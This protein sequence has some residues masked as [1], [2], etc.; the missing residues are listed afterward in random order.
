MRKTFCRDRKDDFY[1]MG[2]VHILYV[3]DFVFVSMHTVCI[4]G[5]CVAWED[6]VIV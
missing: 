6:S 3:D 5:A 4:D 2:E 1:G